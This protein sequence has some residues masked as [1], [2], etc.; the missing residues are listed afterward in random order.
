[1][2]AENHALQ[3]VVE[4]LRQQLDEEVES[5]SE[6]QRLLSKV[7]LR[8]HQHITGQRVEPF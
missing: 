4:Q 5:R 8:R 2:F 6:I 7:R 1:M 3:S